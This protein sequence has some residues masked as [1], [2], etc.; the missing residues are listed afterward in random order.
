MSSLSM[1]SWIMACS[2][3]NMDPTEKCSMLRKI[4]EGGLI[5]TQSRSTNWGPKRI[6]SSMKFHTV[7]IH[8]EKKT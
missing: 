7:A 2:I 1:V 8:D 6:F 3:P 5:Q 4:L